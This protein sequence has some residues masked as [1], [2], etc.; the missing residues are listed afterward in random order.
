MSVFAVV[1]IEPNADVTR[2]IVGKF[3][4]YLEYTP[5]FFLLESDLLA[6]AVAASVGIKGD[7]RIEEASG[8]VIKLEEFSYSGYTSR[9]LWEWLRKAEKK[10]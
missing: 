5:T 4:G 8:F 10:L 7:D 3:P 2:R 9:T 1:L 6:E